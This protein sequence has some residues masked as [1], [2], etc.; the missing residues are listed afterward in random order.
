MKGKDLNNFGFYKKKVL[1]FLYNI[2]LIC[3]VNFACKSFNYQIFLH[4]FC[5]LSCKFSPRQ[6]GCHDFCIQSKMAT[7]IP[8][9]SIASL[10]FKPGIKAGTP[11]KT[12]VYLVIPGFF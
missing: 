6:F 9:R 3:D 11:R 1:S 10:V 5:I 2:Q 7:T 4:M 12:W 8:K